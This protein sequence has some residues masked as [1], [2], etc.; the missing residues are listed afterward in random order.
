[1][2]NLQKIVPERSFSEK[3]SE[4][5][6]ITDKIELKHANKNTIKS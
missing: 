5:V 1:M 3:A 6:E 2:I 4:T